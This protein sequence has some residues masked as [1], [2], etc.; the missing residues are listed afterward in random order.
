MKRVKIEDKLLYGRPIGT[1]QRSFE[2]H[3]SR[4]PT[5]SLSPRL[6]GSQLP[7]KTPIVI[8]TGT[9]EAM[10][11]KFGHYIHRVHK[12]KMPIENFGEKGAWAYSGTAQ[13]FGYPLLSQE[14]VKL[15]TSNLIENDWGRS[16]TAQYWPGDGKARALVRWT[17]RQYSW[18]RPR[19]QVNGN[20][21]LNYYCI[22][23]HLL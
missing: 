5:A 9:D 16:A 18:R 13:F 6:G 8:S 11:F 14:R 17:W 10:D 23:V 12:I 1:H 22:F 15:L 2:R 7:P 21:Y 3:Q 19:L 20:V 4:P